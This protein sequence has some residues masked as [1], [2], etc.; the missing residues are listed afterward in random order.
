M[1]TLARSGNNV[2]L[3]YLQYFLSHLLAP[4]VVN[5]LFLVSRYDTT[6]KMAFVKKFGAV[7]LCLSCSGFCAVQPAVDNRISSVSFKRTLN[8]SKNTSH[9]ELFAKWQRN[10]GKFDSLTAAVMTA[11]VNKHFVLLFHSRQRRKRKRKYV[12]ISGK[13]FL[14]TVYN[15]V[16]TRP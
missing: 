10:R 9:P 8:V 11:A 15:W 4:I 1:S 16:N 5:K 14:K 6:I 13:R 3:T 12:E 7:T 2:R